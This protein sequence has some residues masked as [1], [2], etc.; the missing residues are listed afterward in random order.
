MEDFDCDSGY[1]TAL[2]ATS[3][4][5]L[6]ILVLQNVANIMFYR[7]CDFGSFD[8]LATTEIQCIIYILQLLEKLLLVINVVFKY[9]LEMIISGLSCGLCSQILMFQR[10]PFIDF[11]LSE[12]YLKAN[13]IRYLF[14]ANLAL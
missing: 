9:Q 10:S 2:F 1:W 8:K 14:L 4:S 13:L 12:L 6:V 3:I 7:N 11:Q 5:C